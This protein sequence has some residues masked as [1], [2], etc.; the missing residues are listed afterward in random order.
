VSLNSEPKS[1]TSYFIRHGLLGVQTEEYA[2][3]IENSLSSLVST[4][5]LCGER[6]TSPVVLLMPKSADYLKSRA[7]CWI[8]K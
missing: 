2:L 4:I 5:A 1:A 3:G 6:R 7:A 8:P